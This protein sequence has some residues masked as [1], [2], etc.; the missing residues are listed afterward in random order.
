MSKEEKNKYSAEE[1]A[2]FEGI[3]NTKLDK[4]KTELNYIK[5]TLSRSNDSGT[6][7][8]SGTSKLLEDGADTMKKKT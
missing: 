2:E 5:E 3:I 8:T 7:N 4:A 1:L 6:D